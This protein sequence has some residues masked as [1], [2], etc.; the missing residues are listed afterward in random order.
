M[1][2]FLT[3]FG[4]S[5]F[6]EGSSFKKMSVE[7]KKNHFHFSLANNQDES[8]SW[9]E[10]TG[11]YEVGMAY[12]G[13]ADSTFAWKMNVDTDELANSTHHLAVMRRHRDLTLK[14][15]VDNNLNAELWGDMQL[16]NGLSLQGTIGGNL[17]E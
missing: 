9:K 1:L 8:L 13:V 16:K 15:K 14:G 11:D 3:N 6:L 7:Y 10:W 17:R 4:V 2:N 5:N 12:T